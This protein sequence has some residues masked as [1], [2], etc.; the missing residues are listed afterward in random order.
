MPGIPRYHTVSNISSLVKIR[1]QCHSI[2]ILF[3][4]AYFLL[5]LVVGDESSLLRM[6][7]QLAVLASYWALLTSLTIMLH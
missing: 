2:F 3:D 1:V 6:A 5:A 4:G 7:N